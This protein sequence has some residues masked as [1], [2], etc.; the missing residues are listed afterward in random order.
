MHNFLWGCLHSPFWNYLQNCANKI[1]M[2]H[3]NSLNI[4]TWMHTK[5]KK[6]KKKKKNIFINIFF[7]RIKILKYKC[8][9]HFFHQSLEIHFPFYTDDNESNHHNR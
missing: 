8:P 2:G 6:K 3:K 1:E 4:D 5:K 9:W 7:W